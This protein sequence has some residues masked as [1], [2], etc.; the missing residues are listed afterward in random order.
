MKKSIKLFT[1]AA[2][3]ST[4]LLGVTQAHAQEITVKSGDTLSLYAK[5]YGV[6]VKDIE[7]QNK[8]TSDLIYAGQTLNIN[9]TSSNTYTVKSG[10]C[11]SVIAKANGLTVSKLKSLN[12]LS[13]DVIYPGQTLKLSSTG[14]TTSTTTTTA[15][16]ATTTSSNSTATTY[17]V[18]S[19]DCLSV[20][21]KKYGVT[22]SQLKSWNGLSSDLIKVGQVLKLTSSGQT[23]TQP[24]VKAQ[25]E[26]VTPLA[27]QI[28]K[29]A[30]SY[31]GVPYK[32]GG[33]TPSGFDCSGLVNYVFAKEGVAVSRT[34]ASLYAGGSHVSSLQK[35][36]LVFFTTNG[37]GTVSHVG[38]YI[39]NNEF[40][41]ATSSHGV[42]INS[43]SNSYWGPRYLGAKRY[44]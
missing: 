11:L 4:T 22:V 37:A 30:E 24:E 17:K 43:L 2:F 5:Q 38:I 42:M 34:S 6:S 13:S 29:D 3:L 33:S 35:G 19:G 23:Q 8:L 40:I 31:I 18:K 7:S 28:I 12:G 27:D 9:S 16:K 1:T 10:D 44:L 26:S 15:S 36:D 32:Y 39:G 20:I 14:T 21:A 41:S 25:T